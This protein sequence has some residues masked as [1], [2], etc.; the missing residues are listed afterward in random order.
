MPDPP[1]QVEPSSMDIA[2]QRRDHATCIAQQPLSINWLT[3][4]V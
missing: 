1:Q 4:R 3:R 2:E